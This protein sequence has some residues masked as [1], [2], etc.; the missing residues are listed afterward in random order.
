M[1]WRVL[2]VEDHPLSLELV[3]EFLEQEGCRVLTAL[4]AEEALRL[5]EAERPDLILM[6]LQL[7]GMSGYEATRRLKAHPGTAAIPVVAL[8]ASAMQGDD[9][10]AQEAGCDG[11][12]IKP[13]SPSAFRDALRR[14]LPRDTGQ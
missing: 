3:T 1:A 6:D 4:T 14:F 13:L 8:T 10:K 7:P 9:L 5:A 11:Y 12:L 2:V